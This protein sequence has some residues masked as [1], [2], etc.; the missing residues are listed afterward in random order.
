MTG[1]S[2]GIGPLAPAQ[3]VAQGKVCLPDSVGGIQALF[4]LSC[5]EA[6][7]WPSLNS[8]PILAVVNLR[9]SKMPTASQVGNWPVYQVLRSEEGLGQLIRCVDVTAVSWMVEARAQGKEGDPPPLVGS[10][11][12]YTQRLGKAHFTLALYL[13]LNVGLGPETQCQATCLGQTHQQPSTFI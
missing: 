3:P 10:R 4:R 5:P 2:D 11:G 1:A 9:A 6:P 7:P 12:T 13:M 8:I